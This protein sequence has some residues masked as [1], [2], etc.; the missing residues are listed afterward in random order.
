MSMPACSQHQTGPGVAL[1]PQVRD[2]H[3]A[4]AHTD[5]DLWLYIYIISTIIT[6]CRATAALTAGGNKENFPLISST[7]SY[8]VNHAPGGETSL[9]TDSQ[10]EFCFVFVTNSWGSKLVIRGKKITEAFYFNGKT[11]LLRGKSAFLLSV[12]QHF[13]GNSA[14]LM[15]VFQFTHSLFK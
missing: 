5:L 15:T 8:L 12:M 4:P 11:Q 13:H 14:V 1:C 7:S 3:V 6:I 9:K 10:S 2:L